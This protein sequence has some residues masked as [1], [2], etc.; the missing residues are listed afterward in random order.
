MSEN[1]FT[2]WHVF[3]LMIIAVSVAIL[4]LSGGLFYGYQFGRSSSLATS[5]A[6]QASGTAMPTTQAVAQPAPIHVNVSRP[7]LG[8][9]FETLTPD[10]IKAENLKVN[11]GALI[12]NV[13]PNSPADVAEL[14]AGDVIQSVD[15]QT[16]D[17]TTSLRD[18][19][20]QHQPGDQLSLTVWRAGET[21]EHTIKL[22]SVPDGFDFSYPANELTPGV[23]L[24]CYPGP[25]PSLP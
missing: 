14:K 4:F 6:N 13:M 20:H 10:L 8:V 9:E 7:Y 19:V 2:V 3:G 24:Q 5:V 1:R 15:G 25:C 17:A 11:D 16:L 12:R 21:S 22:G 23:E 18:L